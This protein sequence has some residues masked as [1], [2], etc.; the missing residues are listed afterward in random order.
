M[1]V[2]ATS[3]TASSSSSNSAASLT[4]QAG[5]NTD[6]NSFLQLLTTQLQNQ[7][8]L[9][10]MDDNTFTQQ[11]VEMNGVQQQIQTNSLLQ[12]LVNQSAGAADAVN[13]IGKTVQAASA[14]ATMSN[15]S[16][17]WQYSLGSTAAAA[18]VEVLNAANTVVYS[19][20]APSLSTGP[21]TFTWNGQTSSGGQDTSG[22][23]TLKIVANDSNLQ[24]VTSTIGVQGVVTGVQNVGGVTQLNL[25]ATTVPYSS[26]TQ[27]TNTT[28]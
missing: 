3:P 25:G 12:T 10:P 20:P 14:T 16:I 8:P 1:T 22:T 27:V 26:L 6:Y 17:S 2:A 7:D 19:A 9:S 11:L 21:N 5:L 18:T 4:G 23:Y 13:L 15:G 28:N 24:T